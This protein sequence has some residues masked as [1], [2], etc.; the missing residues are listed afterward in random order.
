MRILL[1]TGP[2][3]FILNAE[4]IHHGW[5]VE[6][7]GPFSAPFLTCEA[8]LSEAHFLL[9]PVSGGRSR[10]LELAVTDR[11][12]VAFSY[13]D[14]AQRVNQLMR[15]YADLPMSFADACLV[16]MSEIYDNSR[17]FTIDSDFRVYQKHGTNPI[18][19]LMPEE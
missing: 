11:I 9:E 12:K 2:L 17:V 19:T 6:Q 18:P 14:H 7:A 16:C 4:D 15:G 1:D 8:V 13:A 5:A 10:L 3:V